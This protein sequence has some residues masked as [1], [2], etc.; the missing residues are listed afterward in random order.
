MGSQSHPGASRMERARLAAGFSV[1]E[2]A[3]KLCRSAVTIRRYETGLTQPPQAV[4]LR[5]A[6]LYG[7][8]P[9]ALMEAD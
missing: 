4:V 8:S 6:A 3:D 5:L 1:V 9:A 7:C 2:V